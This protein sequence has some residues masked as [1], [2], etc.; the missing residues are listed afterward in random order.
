VQKS[1]ARVGA[2]IVDRIL[3]LFFYA[4]QLYWFAWL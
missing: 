4:L 2:E 3:V 1:A